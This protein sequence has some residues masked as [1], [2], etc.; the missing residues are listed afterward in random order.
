MKSFLIVVAAITIGSVLGFDFASGI[1]SFSARPD[2][3]GI[4]LEWHSQIE[5]G[6][7]SYTV[8]RSDVQSPDDFQ[9]AGN[10]AATGSS[11]YYKFHDSPVGAAPLAGQNGNMRTLSDAFRYRL[12]INLSSGDVSYSQTVNVTKPSSGVRRTWGMIKEMF[13]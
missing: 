1:D 6:I 13:H 9:T 12:Q 8:Q 7:T 3:D 5:T 2:G 10:V 4:T 11:S